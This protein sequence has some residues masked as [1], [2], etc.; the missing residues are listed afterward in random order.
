[1]T[2][3]PLP[4]LIGT[5]GQDRFF[6]RIGEYKCHCGKIFKALELSIKRGHQ[7]SC[8]CRRFLG[9][10][11]HSHF[12]HGESKTVEYHCWNSMMQRCY[13]KQHISYDDYGGRGISVCIGWRKSY[14]NFLK[15]MGR[16]PTQNLSLDRINNNG[17]YNPTNCRWATKTEQQNNRRYYG[18]K[19]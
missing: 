4:K 13:R 17:N 7:V 2:Q 5:V 18:K 12:I 1:M 9:G 6:H 3:F 14:L 10:K 8:G 11:Y 19:I 16:K 15:D